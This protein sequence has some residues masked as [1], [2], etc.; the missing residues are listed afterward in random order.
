MN[1]RNVDLIM[2]DKIRQD[3]YLHSFFEENFLKKRNYSS[4][5]LIKNENDEN[6]FLKKFSLDTN[7]QKKR[8][9]HLGKLS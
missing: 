1:L 9:N 4:Y 3:S 7:R 5:Q 2:F 6:F 8:L